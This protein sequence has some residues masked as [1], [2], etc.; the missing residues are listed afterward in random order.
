MDK[1]GSQKYY[2]ALVKKLAGEYRKRTT[3]ERIRK[4]DQWVNEAMRE[5][6]KCAEREAARKN[7]K[8]AT[9]V[10]EE[11]SEDEEEWDENVED[12]L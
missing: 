1:P 10:Q 12:L 6:H 3:L 9:L 7:K 4:A 11:E 5:K 8:R 2:T